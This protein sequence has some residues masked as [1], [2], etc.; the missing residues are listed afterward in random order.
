MTLFIETVAIEKGRVIHAEVF[1]FSVHLGYEIILA[2]ADELGKSH[3]RVISGCY[4]V[5]FIISS[6]VICSPSSSQ[7]SEPPIEAA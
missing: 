1:G 3:S 4:G 7:I 6:T 2:A 5:A